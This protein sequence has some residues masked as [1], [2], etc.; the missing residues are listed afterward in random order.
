MDITAI[1]ISSGITTGIYFLYKS[2]IYMYNNYYLTSE[3]HSNLNS[4]TLQITV[5]DVVKKEDNEI[6]S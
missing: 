4:K 3:C 1:L 6:K 5:G 2:G